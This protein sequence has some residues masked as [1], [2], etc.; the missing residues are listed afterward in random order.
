MSHKKLGP[1]RFSRF[2]VYWIQTNKDKQTDKQT[3][4]PNLYI[5]YVVPIKLWNRKMTFIMCINAVLTSFTGI[6]KFI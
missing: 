3:D 6:L 2:D 1:D 4:K 5:D